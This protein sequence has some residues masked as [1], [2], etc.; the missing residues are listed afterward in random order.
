M[1][2]HRWKLVRV[3]DAMASRLVKDC[4]WVCRRCKLRFI[5]HNNRRPRYDATTYIDGEIADCNELVVS[6]IMKE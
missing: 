6:N 1:R 2:R 3:E 4:I 5:T